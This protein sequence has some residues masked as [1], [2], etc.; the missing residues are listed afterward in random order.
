MA[1]TRA[2][3]A[4]PPTPSDVIAARYR[5]H[6]WPT[7]LVGGSICLLA[8]YV[9][10]RDVEPATSS[11]ADVLNVLRQWGPLVSIAG[12][13]LGS[14][15]LVHRLSSVPRGAATVRVLAAAGQALNLG[16]HQVQ[17]R[18]AQWSTGWR[19]RE[20][21][22]A[23]VLYAPGQVSSDKSADL[24]EA[25][26]PFASGPLTITWEPHTDRFQII[27]T[28]VR[29]PRVEETH[30]G[31]GRMV[32][33]LEHI[34]GVL[35]IDQDLTEVGPTGSV[36]QLVAT[37]KR[38]TRDLS[39]AFRSR[40]KVILDAK[41]PCPSGYW[42]VHLDPAKSRITVTP[43]MPMPT[44][45]EL[46]L[47]LVDGS[48]QMRIPVGVAAGGEPV[49]WKPDEVPHLLVVGPTGSGKTIFFHSMINLVASRGWTIDLIDPKELSYR[50]YMT[51]ALAGRSEQPW[52]GIR[53]V[54]TSEVEMEQ[55]IEA[56]YDEL[57]ERYYQLK[58]FGVTEDQLPPRLLIV[59]EAGEMVERLNAWY[60]S[61]DRYQWLIEKAE[62]E[63][64]D[65]KSV[66]R[67]RGSKHPVLSMLWS[68]LRLGRQARMFVDIGTQRPDVTFIPGEARANLTGRV[69][70][71]KQDGAALEMVFG[72]RTV[73]QR[74]HETRTDPV[75]GE[76]MLQ[77]IR[78]RAT[79]DVGGGPQS[80]QSYWT[81]DP[82]ILITGGDAG[83]VALARR[84][85]QNVIDNS[86]QRIDLSSPPTLPLPVSLDDAPRA[87]QGKAL[88]DKA[89][90][91]QLQK[92]Q[93]VTVKQEQ[94]ETGV[95]ARTL[96]PGNQ[97]WLEVD[98]QLVDVQITDIEDDPS[99]LGEPGE[100]E[101]LQVTYQL[102]SGE[103]GVTTLAGDELV[104]VDR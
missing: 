24:V 65:A 98:G 7:M 12:F 57:R 86:A 6:S 44:R 103:L 17:L 10:V 5:R 76:K 58:V 92:L 2:P 75:T 4:P 52:P 38:T 96:S 32:D 48:E 63:G 54:A 78:G 8:V 102:A 19:R 67:P 55:A 37:Y 68:L 31:L 72:T 84:Q 47:D 42:A 21:V 94:T 53:T 41:V 91:T 13:A 82:S 61:E 23:A 64:R 20:L 45:A 9:M 46:P 88:V 62:A 15:V 25:L 70:L 1:T 35:V 11:Q 51:S 81:P 50:G 66:A 27:P 83:H 74:V 28:P 80:I 22:S 16:P 18:K 59:D 77:R 100:V 49:I 93:T 43:S 104:T 34:L 97:V 101:E 60:G 3:A 79:V 95:L 99:F 40:L 85:K 39:D 87:E 56:C 69:A 90:K 89:M 33:V 73:Q 14:L 26:A 36:Q 30:T 29:P 71:G